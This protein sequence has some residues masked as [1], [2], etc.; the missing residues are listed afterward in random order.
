VLYV[1]DYYS[2]KPY[3]GYALAARFTTYSIREEPSIVQ[4]SPAIYQKAGNR[5]RI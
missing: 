2:L 1:W 5:Y 3:S 4:A